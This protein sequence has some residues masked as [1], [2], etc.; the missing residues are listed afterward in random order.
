MRTLFIS[1]LHLTPERPQIIQ[2]F[3]RFLGQQACRADALYIL[4]DLFEYWIGDDAAEHIG[5]RSAVESLRSLCDSNVPVYIMRG[6]RDFLLGE[7]FCDQTGCQLLTEPMRLCLYDQQVLIM[8]GDSLCTDD[9]DHQLFRKRVLD[10][11]WQRDFLARPILE[12]LE[13][14]LD[15]RKGSENSKRQKSAAEMDVNQTTVESVMR[16]HNV[17]L[18]IHGHTHRAAIHEMELDGRRARRIVLGDWYQHSSVLTW[19]E[20]RYALTSS[21]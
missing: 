1:D 20:D 6:N 13:I 10:P 21:P 15:L 16:T 11:A 17:D 14:A 8:H 18:L 12:R 3:V 5:H 4:G 7:H 2:L 19:S 9:V